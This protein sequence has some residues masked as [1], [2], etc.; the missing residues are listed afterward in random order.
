[1]LGEMQME[2]RYAQP[3]GLLPGDPSTSGNTDHNVS[4]CGPGNS[5]HGWL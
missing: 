1:M 5:K 4:P 3:G 2:V